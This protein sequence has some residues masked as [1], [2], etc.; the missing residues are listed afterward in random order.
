[1]LESIRTSRVTAQALERV[2]NANLTVSM[3]GRDWHRCR[4]VA[5]KREGSRKVVTRCA[6]P[7]YVDGYCHCHCDCDELERHRQRQR[8]RWNEARA[9]RAMGP[10]NAWHLSDGRVVLANTK[11]E[12]MQ[13]AKGASIV[14]IEL[15][16]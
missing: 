9:K 4:S 8:N 3:W 2:R 13:Q 10:R 15:R 12:A 6:L 1:M 16:W 7:G 5:V 11:P 14:H